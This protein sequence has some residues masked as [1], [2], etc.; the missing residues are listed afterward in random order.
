MFPRASLSLFQRFEMSGQAVRFV[1]GI[2]WLAGLFSAA[3]L[4]MYLFA[5][6]GLIRF[7]KHALGQDFVNY[8]T[9]GQL[10]REGHVAD[11]FHQ[12]AFHG[13]EH[14]LFSPDLALHFWS[15]SPVALFLFV[16]LGWL[17]YLPAFV[18]WTLAGFTVLIPVSGA[19]LRDRHE[20]A[21]LLFAP[22]MAFNV[23]FGQN[24][25]FTAALILGGLLLMERRPT[26]AGICFGLMIFKPQLAVLIPVAV[27]AG[28]HWRVFFV[29]AITAVLMVALS[30]L[31]FGVDVWR[32]F[33]TDTLPFQAQMLNRGEGPFQ[34]MM[35][36]AFISAR[37]LG[38]EAGGAYGV[39]ACFSVFAAWAVWH[40]W[41][42]EGDF[43]AKCTVLLAAS[44]LASPHNFIYDLIPLSVAALLFIRM[45]RGPCDYALAVLIW[46]LPALVMVMNA[47][48]APAAPLLLA[49]FVGRVMWVASANRHPAESRDPKEPQT[50]IS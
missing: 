9:A 26:L 41:R 28:G 49:V 40:V 10:L 13:A 8:W 20:L 39:Q 44:V 34:L 15:Y 16:P 23:G 4:A 37:I 43:Y 30:V 14:R 17:S 47:F 2:C 25:G 27:V 3:L 21:L 19:F 6:A 45:G 38:L 32:D 18:A 46:I 48:H 50:F 31:V 35:P 24:A 36:T 42:G 12:E 1:Y 29:A 33:F 11:I 22:A 7:G 5:D